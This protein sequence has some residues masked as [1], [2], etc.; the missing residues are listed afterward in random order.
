[1]RVSQSITEITAGKL[2]YQITVSFPVYTT[3]DQS[4]A[5]TTYENP[6]TIRAYVKNLSGIRSLDTA[7]VEYTDPKEIWVRWIEMQKDCR[8]EL[9]GL[10]YTIHACDDPN[11]KR[12]YLK[13][14]CYATGV[15]S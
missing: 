15:Q 4:G 11:N 7:Q 14:V 12:Q 5:A 10:Y 6:K 3:D 9:N 8:V 1:M 13:I 2:R